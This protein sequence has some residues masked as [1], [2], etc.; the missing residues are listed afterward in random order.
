MTNKPRHIIDSSKSSMSSYLK[1]L[2]E[3]KDLLFVLTHRDFKVRYA[4]ASLGLL[5]AFIQPLAIVLVLVFVFGKALKV[6]TNGIPYPLYAM[7]GMTIWTYFSYVLNQAG[8]SIIASQS[9]ITKIYFPKLIIPISK[10]LVGCVDLIIA[11]SMLILLFF[12]YSYIPSIHIIYLPLFI[13]IALIASIGSGVFLS[14]LSV[15][16]RDFQYVVPFMVQFGLY[17]TPVAYPA[18]FVGEQYKWLYYLNP[19]AGI[20][21]GFRWCLFDGIKLESY[22]LISIA[23]SMVILVTGVLFFRNTEDKMADIV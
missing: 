9:I 1:D 8:S 13:L 3:Y 19:M 15:R 4:Q 6:D 2:V 22:F 21:E 10:A 18:S 12:W 17:V 14:A 7:A 20:I 16:Y 23:S 5:W 11:F